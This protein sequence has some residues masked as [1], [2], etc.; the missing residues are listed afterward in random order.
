VGD[1]TV[2]HRP[3]GR[4]VG[5]LALRPPKRI[6][7]GRQR[8][9]GG[10]RRRD[11]RG[12]PQRH[13]S[14]RARRGRRFLGHRGQQQPVVQ[15]PLRAPG[16]R[17]QPRTRSGNLVCG[18]TAAP[19]QFRHLLQDQPVPGAAGERPGLAGGPGVLGEPPHGPIHDRGGLA[20]S[21]TSP[22]AGC[23]SAPSQ[24]G[25]SSPSPARSTQPAPR[26]GSGP[27]Q[28]RDPPWSRARARPLS[29]WRAGRP[30]F[31]TRARTGSA[32]SRA[33][34]KEI[35][36]RYPIR[37]AAEPCGRPWIPPW[38]TSHRASAGSR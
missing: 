35:P 23:G 30:I 4:L 14:P 38:A 26:P 10:V 11:L 2:P 18:G 27:C 9:P 20:A 22:R 32:A 24:G 21:S 15:P 19:G 33:S 7:A 3:P 28:P 17:R 16:S 12:L 6:S 5:R 1:G 29:H 31:S 8:F 37:T 13:P 36:P 25:C 34:R